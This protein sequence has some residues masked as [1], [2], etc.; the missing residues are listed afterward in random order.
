MLLGSEKNRNIL[1]NIGARVHNTLLFNHS[2][3]YC[4]TTKL[5]PSNL[6]NTDFLNSYMYLLLIVG[7]F[8]LSWDNS[9]VHQGSTYFTKSMIVFAPPKLSKYKSNLLQTAGETLQ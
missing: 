6:L 2:N 1:L 3:Y 4:C 5:S 7:R 8:T 9:L